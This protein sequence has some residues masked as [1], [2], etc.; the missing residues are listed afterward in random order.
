MANNTINDITP[1]AMGSMVDALKKALGGVINK[2]SLEKAWNQSGSAT[3]GIT[4][5]DLEAP[6]KSLVPVITPL[7]NMIPRV[8]GGTG[9]QTNWRAVTAVNTTKVGIGV[10]QGQRGRVQTVATKDYTAPFVTIGLEDYATDEAE[11]AAMGFDDVLALMTLNNLRGLMIGEEALIIGGNGVTGGGGVALG[12]TPTPSLTPSI[13]NGSIA[14]GSTYGVICVALTLTNYLNCDLTLQAATAVPQSGQVTGADGNTFFYNAGTAQKS[15][16][17]TTTIASGNTGS[18]A[19]TVT[20]VP[21]AVAYAW[22]FGVA[23]SEILTQITTINS[24]LITG[25][26]AGATQTPAS[27]TAD[28][29]Q[30]QYVFSGLMSIA[31][32]ASSGAYIKTMATGTAGTGTT[33]TADTN[34][35]CVEID[36]A[37]KSFWD[38]SRLSPDAMWVSSQE[39]AA[40][41]EIILEGGSSAAQRFVFTTDQGNVKGGV[42]VRSYLNKFTMSGNQ[43]IPVHLH[44]NIP[45]GTILFTTSQ[46]PY[47]LSN[48]ANVMQVKTRRDYHQIDWPRKTRRYEYGIYSD[49]VLQHYFPA[50]LGLITNIGAPTTI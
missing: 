36:T 50:S 5:Y 12:T 43:E 35:G 32:S 21:N 8:G 18:I 15:A 11:L 1:T 16:E 45:P 13:S 44:P 49:Q 31:N 34:G 46:L 40:I 41:G 27:F 17:A 23:G 37:L 25:A 33:L 19:A 38:V 20:A 3:S 24:A 10:P 28:Y 22:F 6:A 42:I 30:D 26:T 47:P 2:E 48:V 4:N 7:R 14:T 39:Q 9:T 29:S